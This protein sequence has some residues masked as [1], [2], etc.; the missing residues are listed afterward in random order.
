MPACR[1]R[2]ADIRPSVDLTVFSDS[3]VIETRLPRSLFGQFRLDDE[4]FVA[5]SG[6]DRGRFSVEAL[7]NDGRDGGLV[8]V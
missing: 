1:T 4:V 8:E 5:D 3:S 7:L 6:V 2:S